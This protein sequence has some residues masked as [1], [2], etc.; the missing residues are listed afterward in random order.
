VT[1]GD[2]AEFKVEVRNPLAHPVPATVRLALPDGWTSS[3]DLVELE[4]A[5]GE[6]AVAAFRVRTAGPPRRVPIAAELVLDG[7]QL[8]QHAEALVTVR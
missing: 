6:E 5:P 1:A 7:M 4:V 3:P 2:D 8:G